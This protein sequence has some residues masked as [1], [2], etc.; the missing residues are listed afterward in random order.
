V[1]E[2]LRTSAAHVFV[3]DVNAPQLSDEDAHHLRSVLRVRSTEN[4]SV[5]D[6]AGKWRLCTLDDGFLT[7]RSEVVSDPMR[8]RA[9]SVALVPVKGDRTEWAVEKLVEVGIGEIAI[10][11]PTEFSVVRWSTDKMVTNIERLQ[12]IARAAAMQSRQVWLPRVTGPVV[13]ADLARTVGVAIAEP[14]GAPLDATVH[15][16]VI[17][18]EG[19]FSETELALAHTTVTLGGSILRA[20]TAAVVAGTLM[21]TRRATATDHTGS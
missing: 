9:L 4:V 20:D 10:V 14:T 16:V 8:S 1:N 21:V 7:P 12:R 5:T 18:P 17:G 19:G 3:D 15:T 2:L 6:G 11:S 13:F